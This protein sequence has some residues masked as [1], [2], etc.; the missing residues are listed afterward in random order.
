MSAPIMLPQ[1]RVPHF[2]TVERGGELPHHRVVRLQPGN[3]ALEPGNPGRRPHDRKVEHGQKTETRQEAAP[4]S[5]PSRNVHRERRSVRDRVAPSRWTTRVT[6][7]G[8][9]RHPSNGPPSISSSRRER[10]SLE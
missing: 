9:A 6:P 4:P 7:R 5:A 10:S 3:L 8:R 2:R 1:L